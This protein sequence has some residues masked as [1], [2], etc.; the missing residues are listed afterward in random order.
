MLKDP[1]LKYR[2]YNSVPKAKYQL[3]V[4]KNVLY[5]FVTTSIPEEECILLLKEKA[6]LHRKHR[7]VWYNILKTQDGKT[8]IIHTDFVPPFD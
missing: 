6:Y 5:S 1:P 3:K 7:K 4:Y 8:G 2:K